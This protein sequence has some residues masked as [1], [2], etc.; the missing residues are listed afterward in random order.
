[1]AHRQ[2][3]DTGRRRP[4]ALL[5]VAVALLAAV[6]G[7]TSRA[8]AGSAT[9]RP[10]PASAVFTVALTLTGC[11]LLVLAA[12]LVQVMALRGRPGTSTGARR[13]TT[14]AERL[15]A[16]GIV[17]AFAGT[18]TVLLHRR[19]HSQAHVGTPGGLGRVPHNTSSA[20]HFVG[21]ASLGTLGVVLLVAAIVVGVPLWRR[22][23]LIRARAALRRPLLDRPG[24]TPSPEEAGGGRD[25]L[26]ALLAAV[27]VP[28]PEHEPDPRRAIVAAYLAMTQVAA[29]H[30]AW[31]RPDE[32]PSE[33]LQRLLDHP[34]TPETAVLALTGIFER[35]RYSSEAVG[36]DMRGRA[37]ACLGEIRLGIGATR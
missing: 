1:M 18:F 16:I 29:D 11:L 30:G 15:I 17:A 8:G 27:V 12:M 2:R 4:L 14:M 26:P 36:E 3:R 19:P 10:G 13:R 21:S 35:A 7:A 22:R 24:T 34:G 6:A 25:D 31:R 32:T 28:D 20:V 5:V 33:F 37:L 9:L 23:R